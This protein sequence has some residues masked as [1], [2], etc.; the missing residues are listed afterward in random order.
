[1]DKSSDGYLEIC[2]TIVKEM[3]SNRTDVDLMESLR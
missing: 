3:S 1:M 2:E